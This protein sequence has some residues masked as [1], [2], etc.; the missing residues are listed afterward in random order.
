MRTGSKLYIKK[1]GESGS[2]QNQSG[3]LAELSEMIYSKNFPDN[4]QVSGS[5]TAR[6]CEM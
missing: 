2:S 6:Q 1:G 5:Y 4:K 3:N